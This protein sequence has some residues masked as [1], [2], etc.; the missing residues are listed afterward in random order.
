MRAHREFTAPMS[1]LEASQRAQYILRRWRYK[2]WTTR[3]GLRFERGTPGSAIV[4]VNPHHV[5]ARIDLFL[6]D[7]DDGT[8]KVV[9]DQDVFKLGQP[10][11]RLDKIVW[12]GDL[13]DLEASL[14]RRADLTVDRVRQDRYAAS[15]SYKYLGFVIAPPLFA[16]FWFLSR[17]QWAEVAAMGGLVAVSALILPLLPFRMPDF[18]L[19][20]TL[21]EFPSNYLRS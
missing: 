18:P 12:R 3:E 11:S 1:A 5:H 4:A 13:D 16:L 10:C 8:C 21:P 15:I 2:C 9:V 7:L 19:E 6:A 14:T 17:D 20:N